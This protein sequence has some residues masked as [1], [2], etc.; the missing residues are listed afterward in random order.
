ML[1]AYDDLKSS[2]SKPALEGLMKEYLLRQIGDEGFDETSTDALEKALP[3]V[4]LALK[5][6]ELVVEYSEE[7]ESVAIRHHQ[8]VAVEL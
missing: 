8:Q 3:Q 1:I 5:R 6:G 7:T 4:E 2:L